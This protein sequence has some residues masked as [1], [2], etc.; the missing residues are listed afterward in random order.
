MPAT[1]K[2]AKTNG[3]AAVKVPSGYRYEF[4][5]KRNWR[6]SSD[7][8]WDTKVG[9]E[10]TGRKLGTRTIDGAA[11]TGL[12]T[13]MCVRGPGSERSRRAD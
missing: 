2:A 13:R 1:K 4:Q 12:T 10:A 3:T 8:K 7:E 6:A 11:Y 9:S 5:G